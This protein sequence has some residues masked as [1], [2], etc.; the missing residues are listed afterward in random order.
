[1]AP[2]DSDDFESA[3]FTAT[4]TKI[5]NAPGVTT[6]AN[7]A[8]LQALGWGTNQNG[9]KVIQLDNLAEWIWIDPSGTGS[10]KR[11]NTIGLLNQATQTTDA[12]T[13]ATTGLGVMGVQTGNLTGPGGRYL[14]VHADIGLASTVGVNGMAVVTLT[15]NG[16]VL[17]QNGYRAGQK[18]FGGGNRTV[19]DEFI[20]PTAGSV[21]NFALWV[22]AESATAAL[23][24]GGT[25][26]LTHSVLTVFEI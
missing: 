23:G 1:M 6:V 16:S 3:D 9:L 12:S 15:D 19:L 14:Q 11:T 13:S 10:F 25:S 21:H 4:F 18:H 26:T 5:D 22:R 20:L 2:V 24:G 8:G 17:T 7:Y